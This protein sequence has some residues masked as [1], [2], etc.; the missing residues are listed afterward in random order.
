LRGLFRSLNRK[1]KKATK[2]KKDPEDI[3]DAGHQIR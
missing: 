1:G 3:Q 2:D